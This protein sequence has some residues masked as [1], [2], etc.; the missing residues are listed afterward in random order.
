M[1]CSIVITSEFLQIQIVLLFMEVL[2]H[3]V[4]PSISCV[5][6]NSKGQLCI[7]NHDYPEMGAIFN[8]IFEMD[9]QLYFGFSPEFISNKKGW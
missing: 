8:K 6:L 1:R 9:D 4:D 2:K 7:P 3:L 5:Y